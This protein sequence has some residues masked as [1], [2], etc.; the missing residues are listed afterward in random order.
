[1]D[2][3]KEIESLLVSLKIHG[4][5]RDAIEQKLRYSPNYIDQQ[6]SKGGNKRFVQALEDLLQKTISV[7]HPDD[8]ELSVGKLKVTLKD[9]FDLLKEKD[10][11]RENH[12]ATLKEYTS[13]MKRIIEAKLLEPISSPVPPETYSKTQ[14]ELDAK[15]AE[16]MRGTSPIVDKAGGIYQVK[17]KKS[18]K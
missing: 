11:I 2:F 8:I 15:A 17:K 9:H 3:R 14:E 1:M 6:L 16:G 5:D 18:G 10:R 4:L 12:E 13:I 7:A